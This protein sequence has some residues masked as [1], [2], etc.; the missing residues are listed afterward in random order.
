MVRHKFSTN[1]APFGPCADRFCTGGYRAALSVEERLETASRVDGLDGIE[2]FAGMIDSLGMARIRS[3]LADVGLE[4]SL[5]ACGVWGDSSWGYGSFSSNSSSTRRR[6]V[7]T[8]R[9]SMDYAAE[10]GAGRVNLWLGQDGHDYAFQVDYRDTWKHMIDGLGECALHN[11]AVRICI[12]P[13]LCEPRVRS[14][15]SSVGRLLWLCNRIGEPNIGVNVDFG[16][17]MQA[18]ES[19]AEAAVLAAIDGRLFHTH[20]NDAYPNW[21]WDLMP[22]TVHPYELIETCFWLEELGYDGWY[23]LDTF[24]AREDNVRALSHGIAN[25][26]HA[27]DLVGRLDKDAVRDRLLAHDAIG[28]RELVDLVR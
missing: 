22:G 10:L 1:V 28:V 8:L 19:P 11:P 20:F 4:C 2:V 6:A 9:R 18:W 5:V 14:Q 16:H 27:L 17:I 26:K 3:V 21:D 15:I 25:V 13:K 7:D 12:E 24:P 23:S